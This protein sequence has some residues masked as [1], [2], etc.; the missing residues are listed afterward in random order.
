MDSKRLSIGSL[1]VNFKIS[2]EARVRAAA[3]IPAY[4]R[5]KRRIEDLEEAVHRVLEDTYEQ[6]L[7][8]HGGDE[9]TARNIVREQAQRMDLSLLNDLIDRHNRYYP[10]EA[11]LPTDIKTGRWMLAGKPWE[12]LAP[13]TWQDFCS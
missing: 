3:G 13:L 6:A 8:E 12:P 4:M 9:Q 11:N 10:I 7:E 5:R 2:L 1:P